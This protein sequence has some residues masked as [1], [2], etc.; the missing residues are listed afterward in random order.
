M[1][2]PLSLPGKEL[3]SWGKT[4]W[5]DEKKRVNLLVCAGL[6]GMLLLAFSEWIPASSEAEGSSQPVEVAQQDFAL[7]METRL[8]TLIEAMEGVGRAKVMVTLKKGETH[9]FAS[10]RTTTSDGAVTTNHVVL[11]DT[12]MLET[13]REPEILGVAVVC[14]G[15]GNASVQN[16]V[17]ALVEALTGVG[18]NHIT[19]AEMESTQ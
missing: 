5:A 12:G 18:A 1:K 14:I 13:I 9:I 17:S 4:L 2:K 19:V 7:D 11:G 16:R 15:G 6:A 8:Q 10:D 3:L